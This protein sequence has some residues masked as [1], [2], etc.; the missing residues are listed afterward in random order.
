MWKFFPVVNRATFYFQYYV[1]QGWIGVDLFFVLSGF[2]ITGILID[3]RTAT[4]YFSGFY[5]RRILRIFP[6]YYSVLIGIIV[7][8]Q[9]LTRIHAP[10]APEIASLVPLPQDRWTYFLFLTNWIGLWKAQWDAQFGSILAHF[11]S[12]GVEEQFY[13]FWPLVVWLARPR[14]IP[15]IAAALAGFSMIVRFAWAAHIG[16]QMLI[17]PISVEIA[18]AT[19]CRLDALFIGALCAYFFRAP[20][21]MPR[22]R[23]WL[24]LTAALGIGSYFL[25]FS[26]MLFFPQRAA[27]LLY[28][29]TP[30]VPHVLDDAIRLFLVSGGFT[31]LAIGFG[32]TVLLAACTENKNTPMQKFL[33]SRVLAPI[34]KYS[35]GIYVFHVPVLGLS[36]TYLLPKLITNN[37]TEAVATQCAYIVFVATL[38]FI[39]AALSYELFEKKILSFKRYFGPRYAPEPQQKI[40]SAI[41]GA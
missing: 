22:I 9:I 23:R 27:L 10:S 29:P 34:G 7:A 18:L 40:E 1:S 30:V 12:L 15:W 37:P 31:L 24:P 36:N 26:A 13:F 20:E 4:N 25:G 6:L 14:S 17:P 35:Y 28:G 32:A 19:I 8:S 3:S 16:P 41:A 39:I 21:L 38:S 33:Q 5:A 11:W 2:L